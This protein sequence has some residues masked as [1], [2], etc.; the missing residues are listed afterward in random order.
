MSVRPILIPPLA[1]LSLALCARGAMAQDVDSIRQMPPLEGKDAGLIGL[2]VATGG[3]Y[4]GADDTRTRVLPVL[5][6]HWANGWFASTSQGVG[7][8]MSS[9]PGL[10]Y[11][12]R[13][14]LDLGRRERDDPLLRG[15]GNVKPSAE[16]GG[17]VNYR[18]I[19]ALSLNASVRAGAGEDHRGLR[20]DF[21]AGWGTELAPGLRL[22]VGAGTT[23]TNQAYA[24][25]RY[26]VN[27]AQAASSGYASYTPKAGVQD[28]HS[29]VGLNY[30]LAPRVTLSTSLTATRLVGDAKDSPLVRKAGSVS[31]QVGVAYGF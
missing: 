18:V 19:D 10:Q 13:V 22:R 25:S 6:Y 14:T 26:G 24:Q 1:L 31:G 5:G 23:V 29:S 2:G 7:F 12:P 8:N 30:A 27:A 11:G 20:A 4:S 15:L 17:F 28:V 9:T 16:I 3:R 21:G